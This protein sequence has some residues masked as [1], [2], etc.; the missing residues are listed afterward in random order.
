MIEKNFTHL[1]VHTE[2]S[3]LDGAARI[4]E[5]LDCAK[6]LGMKNLAITDH[7]AMYGVMNFYKTALKKNIKPI[8]GCEVYV[9]PTTRFLR[10]IVDGV[11]YFHLILLAENNLGYKNLIKLVSLAA[12]EGFYYKPRIDKEILQKY[13]EGL[14][15]LSACTAGE[16][17]RAILDNNFNKAVKL[18][19]EYQNIFGQGNFFLEIQNHGLEDEKIVRD[20]LAKISRQLN[21]PLV[22][23][24][25][26]HYTRR[27]DYQAHDILLCIQMNKTL[28]DK[29]R[30]R[31]SSDD[32]YLKS[33]EDMRNIFA[34]YPDACDNTNKIAERCNVNFE[35]GKLQM[36]VYPLPENYSDEK[37]LRELCYKK[38]S[39]RYENITDEIKSRLDY[40]LEIINRMGYAGYFL[41]V[42][43]FIN[44]ARKNKIPVGPGRGS[45]AGSIVAYILEITA[46]DPI[47]FNLLFERFL[48]P[49]RI[50]MPDID[51]DF[52]YI[53]REEVIEYVKKTYGENHVAQIVTFG[54]LA[55]KAAVRDVV[56]ALDIPYSEGSRIIDMMPND[57]KFT[58]DEA[59]S[60]S[61]NLRREYENNYTVRKIIDLAK[62][63]EGMPRHSSVH[64]AG[65]VISKNP[66]IDYVPV[67]ISN[68]TLITQY[69]KDI[70]EELG[71]LKMDFLGLRTLTIIA[72][73]VDNIKK[74]RGVDIDIEKIPLED[75]LT[76]KMLSSGDTG[77]IFQMESP[78]MINMIKSLRPK[79]FYDL[80]PTVA[81]YRPGPLASGMVKNFIDSKHGVIQP[82]YLHEKLEPILKETFGVIL[83][84]EQ[85]MQIVQVLAGF[86]LS[87]ADILRRAIGKKKA[88]ILLAQENNFMAG[89][90]KN[91][92]S[93]MLARKIFD[94][95]KNFA[96][97]GFNKSH[98]VAYAFLA[99]QTAYLKAHYPQEFM[100]A[101]MSSV[102]DNDKV[103]IYVEMT[104]GM[105]I[106]VLQPDI[107]LSGVHFTVEN[108]S[109]RFALSAIKSLGA[110]VIE[111]VVAVR[112]S[113]GKFLSLADFCGRVDTRDFTRRA[114]ENLI[115]CGA[116]D[117]I[118][119]RRTALLESLESA[120]TEGNRIKSELASGQV[121]LFGEDEIFDGY[122]IP[123]IVERPKNEILA[124]EK[125]ILGFYISGH[126]LDEFK[127]IISRLTPIKNILS[128]VG[129]KIKIGGTV[130]DIK[131]FT[132]KKG[133]L[134]AFVMLEDFFAN[135]KVTIFPQIFSK[136]KNLIAQDEI[137]IVVGRVENNNSIQILADEIIG[138]KNYLPDIY[139]TVTA[140]HK[141]IFVSER[142]MKIF[143][144]NKGGCQVY[145]NE[146][147]KWKRLDKKISDDKK[148]IRQ[149]KDLLGD[150]N[151]RIY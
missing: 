144:E 150:E 40:E 12:T 90:A 89:C 142:L 127:E 71:L 67:Q 11:K 141:K 62:K 133:D 137:I 75:N 10:E 135:I 29:H 60:K 148:V 44:F 113:G 23:T 64:A 18:A 84:Q 126:P 35:F 17:P 54:T 56:R 36:P 139:L 88:D 115:K 9:A 49:E 1:H 129:K 100:A 3:L 50:S 46:I 132:T 125:E 95:L 108:N 109:V 76:A 98:S 15:A 26:V 143:V 131:I 42:W 73:A 140:E 130:T 80:I 97:Y 86:T 59:L 81:L 34:E 102:M 87:Q 82:K 4:T 52:C 2:Y 107:N 19:E 120:I 149:L 72:E 85:V 61:K 122:K 41:I 136:Y 145:L 22:A 51:I 32:Y 114:L 119:N 5:L 99:W 31:F 58:I 77:A 43:D 6:N 27:E 8:I 66:L 83:Y 20:N 53:R 112:E 68:D 96:D 93:E 116:F 13:H 30:L 45:A 63:L 151:V 146:S 7:G 117:S 94:L 24:N 124:W 37:Y 74:I 38:I 128:K 92:I 55:A 25:D 57:L 69:D 147:G 106:K 101:M 134:M 14:I 79:N 21:I 138:A 123:D 47:K 121:G 70:I 118:D 39:A 111:K 16:I 91:N 103:A 105:G 33:A 48:N 110:S 104:R 65:V 78:G 28:H